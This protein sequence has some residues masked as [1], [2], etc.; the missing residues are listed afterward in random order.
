MAVED[1]TNADDAKAAAVKWL[2]VVDD[3]T[4]SNYKNSLP[5]WVYVLAVVVVIVVKEMML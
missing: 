3:F 4:I 2:T 1:K 5:R